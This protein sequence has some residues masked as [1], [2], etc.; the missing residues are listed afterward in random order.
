MPRK[1]SRST[2]FQPEN[3]SE[4]GL[5]ADRTELRE[6]LAATLAAYLEPGA[7]GQGRILVRG[8]RGV[9]KSM[10]ARH[11]IEAVVGEYGPLR[12]E[13]DCA[14]GGHGPE[15]VLR[16]LARALARET[17]LNSTH[18][19]L[20]QHAQLLQNFA[21]ATRVQHKTVSTWTRSTNLKLGV[22]DKLAEVLG[23]EFGVGYSVARAFTVD[24]S[25][26]RA[27]DVALLQS[28]I[29][30]FLEDSFAR[31]Q[32]TVLLI[33]NLDQAGYAELEE[34][35]RRVTDLA[36][37]LLSL[38]GCVVV[39]TM[40]TEFVSADLRKLQSYAVEVPGMAPAELMEVYAARVMARG[41]GWEERLAEAG[42]LDLAGTLST[43]TDNAWGFLCWLA[44]SD[45]EPLAEPM[46]EPALKEHMRRYAERNYPGL[47]WEELRR[48]GGA[49]QDAPD[50]WRRRDALEGA[51]LSAELLDRALKYGALVPD[52]LLEPDRWM[53]APGLHFLPRT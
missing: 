3:Y 18:P 36:R 14:S 30:A 13:V 50:A 6:L 41:E 44:F 5:F 26:D 10:L 4:L 47:T 39:A 35:V 34:D 1:P 12:V 16:Q 24:E 23:V 52:W 21:N 11:A 27:V 22:T 2:C 20:R 53:L 29:Q 32:H 42:L 51:G 48:I 43:W 28:L 37:A 19:E 31:G 33:D 17:L 38:R 15:A 46:D 8:Q 49:Y 25:A 40:R 7:A 9:G 45:F